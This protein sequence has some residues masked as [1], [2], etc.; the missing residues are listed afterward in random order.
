Q[1][2]RLENVIA[3]HNRVLAQQLEQI[4]QQANGESV[5][6]GVFDLIPVVGQGLKVGFKTAQFVGNMVTALKNPSKS[7]AFLFAR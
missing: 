4:N 3:T 7:Q 2:Q 6:D 1:G 5:I